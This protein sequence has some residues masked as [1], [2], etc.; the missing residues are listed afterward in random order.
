M[1]LLRPGVTKQHKTKQTFLDSINGVLPI[2]ESILWH[3]IKLIV[4]TH[5]ITFYFLK[6]FLGPWSFIMQLHAQ[7]L[8]TSFK[9]IPDPDI[10]ITRTIKSNVPCIIAELSWKF[11]NSWITF[12]ETLPTYKQ[13]DKQTKISKNTTFLVE[14]KCNKIRY[15]IACFNSLHH[16]CI[17]ATLDT[18]HELCRIATY[19]QWS[20]SIIQYTLIH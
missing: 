6:L 5:C 16:C 19:I 1:S 8:K 13:T 2:S 9:K 14:V 12:W 10:W 18:P 15:V 4:I 7:M 20:I 17:R 11:H 3:I